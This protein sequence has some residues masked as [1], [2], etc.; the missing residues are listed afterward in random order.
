MRCNVH[1]VHNE[2]LAELFQGG[3]NGSVVLSG[4]GAVGQNF[5]AAAKVFNGSEVF[6]DP[7][8]FLGTMHEFSE[9]DGGH[10]HAAGI[11]VEGG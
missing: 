6:A 9:G 1:V 8:A 4:F 2:W 5:Q 7:A 11:C 10:C 3:A